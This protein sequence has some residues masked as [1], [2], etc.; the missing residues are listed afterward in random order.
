MSEARSKLDILYQDVLGEIHDVITRVEKLRTDI[1]AVTDQAAATIEVQTGNLLASS[2]ALRNVLMDMAKQV[3]AYATQA[4]SAAAEAAKVDIRQ[5]AGAA[6]GDALHR[7]VG[8]EVQKAV[9]T[10]NGA[11]VEL[12]KE[13]ERARSSVQM[14]SRQVAWGWGQR[15]ATM[16]GASIAGG[17]VV[18]ALLHLSGALP[19]QLSKDD[20]L[21][22]SNGRK[23]GAIW[24]QLTPKERERI[25]ELSKGK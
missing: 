2:E 20:R 5:T 11:A 7:A 23:L 12:A 6:A 8:A 21:A 9:S 18:V 24:S 14:A 10:L 19:D 13:A 3:D 22:L 16:L 4:T 25:E 15:L 17:L 1:P